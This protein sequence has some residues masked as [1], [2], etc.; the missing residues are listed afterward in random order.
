ML[1]E[2]I[3]MDGTATRVINIRETSLISCFCGGFRAACE[4]KS[5]Q[6]DEGRYFKK[7]SHLQ[8]KLSKITII[9]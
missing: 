6:K 2:K 1:N 4:K 8:A 3:G 9:G 5:T 7:V